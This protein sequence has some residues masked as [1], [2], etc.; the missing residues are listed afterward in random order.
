MGTWILLGLTVSLQV[1][2]EAEDDWTLP[3]WVQP[4][5]FSGYYSCSVGSLNDNAEVRLTPS[6]PRH[7]KGKSR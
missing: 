4:S 7:P 6:P 3:E 5:P 2:S 1:Q